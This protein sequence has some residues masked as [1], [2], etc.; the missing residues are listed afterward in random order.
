[1]YLRLKPLF[2]ALFAHHFVATYEFN[3]GIASVPTSASSL[4]H[5]AQVFR[6][7]FHLHWDNELNIFISLITVIATSVKLFQIIRGCVT[8]LVMY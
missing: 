8:T 2:L 1:M 3:D 4:S 5:L 7:L 6:M